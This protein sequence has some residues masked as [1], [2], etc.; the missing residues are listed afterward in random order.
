MRPMDQSVPVWSNTHSTWGGGHAAGTARAQH[1]TAQHSTQERR[2]EAP[3]THT[4]GTCVSRKCIAKAALSSWVGTVRCH[5]PRHACR[6]SPL[7]RHPQ[8]PHVAAHCHRDDALRC[9]DLLPRVCAGL[10]RRARGL[11][12]GLQ[13]AR[14]LAAV[15]AVELVLAGGGQQHHV[16]VRR[17][18]GLR[19][20]SCSMQIPGPCLHAVAQAVRKCAYH[21]YRVT[22]D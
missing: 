9:A 3:A 8:A 17:P 18:R 19:P 14:G 16:V 6:E 22:Q 1:S 10:R 20:A 7:P 4:P 15:A 21:S 11:G 13:M 5:G 2:L 12:R